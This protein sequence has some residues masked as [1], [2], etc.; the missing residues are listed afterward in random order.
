MVEA[1][2]STPHRD[3]SGFLLYEKLHNPVKFNLSQE[4]QTVPLGQE[5]VSRRQRD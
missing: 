2:G 3:L 5:G 1:L 4:L